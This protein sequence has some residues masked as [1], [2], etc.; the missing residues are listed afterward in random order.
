VVQDTCASRLLGIDGLTVTEVEDDEAGVRVVYAVTSADVVA[1]CPTCQTPSQSP[2]CWT[3]T[4]PR[5]LDI[6]GR[7]CALVWCKRRWYC[8]CRDCPA[9]SF[10]ETLPQIPARARVT[11]RLRQSAGAA[12]CDGGR[13]VTQSGRDHGLSWPVVQAQFEAA[14]AQVLPDAPPSTPILGIDE[15]RRGKARFVTDADT[16]Q[17]R[18]VVDR[19]L[20]GFV[21]LTGR[22]G[23]VG[24]VEGRAGVDVGSWLAAQPQA[25]RDAVHVVAIDMSAPYRAAIREH[26]PHATIVADHFH[27]VQLANAKLVQV[28]RRITATVRG[29]RAHAADPEYG[30]RRRLQRNH[31]DL[32]PGQ[33]DDMFT[34]L[35]ALGTPG[36]QIKIAYIAKEELRRLLH[37]AR[38]DPC[39]HRIG[40]QLYVFYSWCA[41]GD[42][43]ELTQ[44]ARSVEA[45]WPQIEA[46][47]HTGITNA[48]SEAT[49]RVS[50]LEGRNAYGFRNPH[51]QRLRCMA[52]STRRR[53]H[54]DRMAAKTG[55]T[56]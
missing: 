36:E 44:L 41:A 43:G 4:L 33:F 30:I 26:L 5:D 16:G 1:V 10:T 51:H 23:L 13:T 54:G 45:W 8:R 21:D 34:R 39:R 12:V 22:H 24:Q 37:L 53:R 27:L 19:W 56:R 15:I 17:I 40:Q 52:A 25:W 18:Q 9:T 46:F 14:A 7:R 20:T 31:E 48:G 6:G 49:N 55:Q 32:K 42:I 35:D 11:G 28:R 2:K 50:K 3:T 38:T 47:L 29:R